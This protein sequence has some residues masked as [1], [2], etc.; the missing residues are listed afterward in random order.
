MDAVN[1]MVKTIDALGCLKRVFCAFI[2]RHID[3]GHVLFEQDR[4][5]IV[6]MATVGIDALL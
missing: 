3:K 4:S 5:V 6:N 1:H 2:Q